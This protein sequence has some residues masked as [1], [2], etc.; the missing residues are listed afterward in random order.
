M[1]PS[2]IRDA[3]LADAPAIA[4]LHLRSWLAAYEAIAPAEAVRVLTEEVRRDRWTAMLAAPAPRW[5]CRVIAAEGV[6]QA[7]GVACAPSEALFGERGEVRHLYVEPDL[8]RAGLGRR[9]M[10]ELTGVIA[11]WDYAGLALSVVVENAPARAFYAALGGR[12]IGRFTDPGPVWRSQNIALAWDD[13]PA[14]Q[15]RLG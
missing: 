4:G 15:A 12:E 13:L 11:G 14:L 6:I 7:V 10:A 1:P 8:R 5:V 2:L 9:M 3:A